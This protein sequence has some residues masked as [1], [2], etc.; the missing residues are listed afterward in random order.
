MSEGSED[1]SVDVAA[2]ELSGFLVVVLEI[3]GH[4]SYFLPLIAALSGAIDQMPAGDRAFI[5]DIA[6]G[7]SVVGGTVGCYDDVGRRLNQ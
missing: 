6:A 2:R 3:L 4:L 5:L 1:I 7:R